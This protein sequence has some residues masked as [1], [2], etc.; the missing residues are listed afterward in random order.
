MVMRI[1]LVSA[2]L[3]QI[4]ILKFPFFLPDQPAV[5]QFFEAALTNGLLRCVTTPDLSNLIFCSF[6]PFKLLKSW[7][8]F[9]KLKTSQYLPESEGKQIFKCSD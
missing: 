1:N 3:G 9:Q 5:S 6:F 4:T 2:F 8:L 7:Y